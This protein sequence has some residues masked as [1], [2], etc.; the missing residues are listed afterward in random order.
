[1]TSSRNLFLIILPLAVAAG[2]CSSMDMSL[3]APS[4][5]EV[6]E[7]EGGAHVTWKDNSDNEQMFMVERKEGTGQFK[8][9]KG[10]LEF[11]TTAW[12]DFGVMAGV[13]YT[14]RVMAMGKDGK[15]SDYS[16]E[17]TFM[18]GSG[19]VASDAGAT[20]GAGG[21]D[22]TGGQGGDAGHGGV[23]AGNSADSHSGHM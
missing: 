3:K 19:G 23:D 14:Y 4:N 13:K 1:M 16:N 11:N 20:G 5:L 10:D 17:A 12:H 7:L 9:V 18:L 2:S 6:K 21:H 8:V 22:G 15:G